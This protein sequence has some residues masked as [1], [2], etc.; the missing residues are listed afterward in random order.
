MIKA[1]LANGKCLEFPDGTDPEAIDRAVQAYL[2]RKVK[3]NK[4]FKKNSNALHIIHGT[5][6]GI[7]NS[8]SPEE[9]AAKIEKFENSLDGISRRMDMIV[10]TLTTI[11]NSKP[12]T[13]PDYSGIL[14]SLEKKLGQIESARSK[15]PWGI[16]E[17]ILD[18]L[19][20][21]RKDS[22][23]RDE[24]LLKALMS[25]RVVIKDKN[26]KVTGS[27]IKA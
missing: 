1:Q 27:K 15:Q 19:A 14:V 17:K 20:Q 9:Q 5:N 7:M 2:G 3:K 26:G 4:K 10:A 12:D 23:A 13:G 21:M 16:L 8:L 6:S 25:E 24:R 11:R 22:T 18:T